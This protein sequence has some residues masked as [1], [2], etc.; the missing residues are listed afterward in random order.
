MLTSSFAP[1]RLLNRMSLR[2]VIR[3]LLSAAS[4]VPSVQELVAQAKPDAGGVMSILQSRHLI[5]L[6]TNDELFDL[7]ATDKKFKLY[8]G[9]DPS[10]PSLHLGNL[11]PLMVL[12]NFAIRGHSVVGLVGGATG[13]VGDPSGRTSERQEMA[14]GTRITNVGHIEKQMTTF[15]SRG[16]EYAKLRNFPVE[17]ATREVQN[18]YNWWKD[19]GMLEFLAK[20]GRHI[21]V[22]QMLARDS[23]SSRLNSA[24]GL[25]FNEF[26]YQIL[27]AYDF[28]HLFKVEGVN[29]Q[30]GG[31][32]QWGNITAGVDLIL[33]LKP[34]KDDNNDAYGV[35][36]PLLTT[37]LGEKFG[38]SAG[39]AVFI[40]SEM[41]TPYQL[42]QFFIN[43][44]DE[45]VQRLLRLFTLLPIEVVDKVVESSQKD[46]TLRKAQRVLARE[47]VDLLHGPG[48]GDEMAYISSFLFNT[49]DMPFQDEVSADKLIKAFEKLGILHHRQ[50]L[51]YPN[52]DDL[53]LSTLLADIT[54]KL[55]REIKNLL[56]QGAVYVGTDRHQVQDPD[57][58]I[59]F[60]KERLIDD[61]LLLVRL[62]KNNYYVVEW[63]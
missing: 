58:I 27:Q 35:T 15:F 36:V 18:N 46:P 53:K 59:L 19:I 33:R 17:D 48:T 41:T 54:G 61:K 30:V 43:V 44:P 52:I 57:D 22:T 38:K 34:N 11:L 25:G 9:A 5:E 14:D 20:Y 28:Y 60:D 47:V 2:Q 55:K 7:T 40:D 21:R 3:R 4:V 29:I 12:L 16:I 63:K 49:P 37:P 6:V 45:M 26:T 10:A 13:A 50:F 51:D 32:D 8:C 39:N 56:A 24:E 62:G 42:Y 31:N 1:V 23:I